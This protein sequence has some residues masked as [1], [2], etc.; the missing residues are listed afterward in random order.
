MIDESL[1][2]LRA[3]KVKVRPCLPARSKVVLVLCRWR[4]EL[5]KQSKIHDAL[6]LFIS[7]SFLRSSA[8]RECL[9][10]G[11]TS[12][13]NELPYNKQGSRH[14]QEQPNYPRATCCSLLEPHSL[15]VLLQQADDRQTEIGR[16]DVEC[17]SG[18][19]DLLADRGS[20]PLGLRHKLSASH[21]VSYVFIHRRNHLLLRLNC[22]TLQPIGLK[23]AVWNFQLDTAR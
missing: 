10:M 4:A 11:L 14:S 13:G 19:N 7:T 16:S 15:M 22:Q 3:S 2:P 1:T 18:K 12:K 8:S 9:Q 6:S 5:K 20:G 23:G 17:S 21:S